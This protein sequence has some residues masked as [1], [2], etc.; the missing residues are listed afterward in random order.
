VERI[1]PTVSKLAVLKGASI[2]KLDE[3]FNIFDIH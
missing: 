2:E 1:P 3:H